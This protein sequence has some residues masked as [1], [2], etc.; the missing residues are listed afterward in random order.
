MKK[1]IMILALLLFASGMLFSQSITLLGSTTASALGSGTGGLPSLTWNVPAGKNRA[2]IVTVFFE[3][4]GLNNYPDDALPL[5]INGIDMQGGYSVPFSFWN[6]NG[7]G[8]VA[9]SDIKTKVYK[10]TLTDAQS[11]PTGTATF[12][13]SGIALPTNAND[14][15]TVSVAVF[16]NVSPSTSFANLYGG[17]T[18]NNTT[19]TFSGSVPVGT[20]VLGRTLADNLNFAIGRTSKDATLGVNAGWTTITNTKVT[21]GPGT[22]NTGWVTPRPVNEHDGVSFMAV[23]QDGGSARTV[24]FSGVGTPRVHMVGWQASRLNPLAK[25]SITGNVYHDIDGNTNI[26]GSA[27]A[28][29]GLYVNVVGTDGNVVASAAVAVDGTFTVPSSLTGVTEGDTYTL[30]LSKNQGTVGQPAPAIALNNDWTTVGEATSATGNDGTNNGIITLTAGTTNISG[31]RYGI[32]KVTNAVTPG[33]VAADQTVISGGNPAAFTVTTAATGSG[34]MSYQWQSSTDSGANWA[35]ISGATADT[36]DVPAGIAITTQYRRAAVSTLSGTGLTAYSNVIT[37]T[38]QQSINA[39]NICPATT[40][41]LG[42]YFIGTAPAGTSLVWFNNNTHTGS[43][44]SNPSAVGAGTYYAYYYDAP[45]TCYS[46]PSIPVNVTINACPALCTT[47]D[48]VLWYKADS[49]VN[50]ATGV[51]ADNT[52]LSTWFDKT[53]GA[54][55]NGGTASVH[56]GS[57]AE[58]DLPSMPYYRYDNSFNFNFNPVVNFNSTNNGQAVQFSTP[59]KG[60]QTVFTVFKSAGVNESTFYYSGLLYGGDAVKVNP[61]DGDGVP[62]SDITLGVR[63]PGRL[64][65][66]GGSNGDFNMLGDI[67]LNTIPSIGTF[68]RDRRNDEEVYMSMYGSGST[69]ILNQNADPTNTKTG[70]GRDLINSLRIGKAFSAYEEG[71]AS[72]RGKLNGDFAELLVYNYVLTDADRAK[73]ESYLAI[74]YGITLT[75]GTKQ[76][77][78]LVGNSNYNYVTNTGTVIRA[79][80]PVYKYDVFGLGKDNYYS[81]NQ[82]I[83]KSVNPGEIL[84]ASTNSNFISGNL[85]TTRTAITGDMKYL[86]FGNN[87]G[88]AVAVTQQ[89]TELP[90]GITTRLNREWKAAHFNTD[91][92]NIPNFSLRFDIS[93]TAFTAANSSNLR[94]LIDTDGDG[95]FTTGTVTQFSPSNF[96]AGSEAIFTSLNITNGQVFTL[97]LIPATYCYKPGATTGGTVRDTKV[98]ISAL[99]RAGETDTDN[100]PMTR[101]GGWLALEAKTKAFVPNRVA[102]TDADNNSSTPDTP[103]GI[104]AANFVEGM[105]VYDTTNKC[106]KMYT[107]KT[108]DT[109]MAWHCVTTQACPD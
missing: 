40:V 2:M 74:K 19:N 55:F 31:L 7:G 58:T 42:S 76:A 15:V 9:S 95:D 102:F 64:V 97:G 22:D 75:G 34:T 82:R 57:P 38:V 48:A 84:T 89:T 103:V 36:Y 66:G 26:N 3:R 27:T 33:V 6:Q 81:L 43:P 104:A 23:T 29:G 21:N 25:P 65:L 51:P 30:Q 14:E 49:G 50:T 80:E 52:Q 17:S 53:T 1:T 68:K 90:T 101:K 11:L 32:L 99:G 96:T 35:D 37:V 24:T 44:V 61:T 47:G 87:T 71:L 92:A 12:D 46:P 85:D 39:S 63:T 91:A 59:A 83:S 56:P 98:G 69:D 86:L 8:D 5:K 77:G 54:A 20:A 88:S 106:L 18:L 62:K 67:Q 4:I 73:V 72:P 16:G 28:G 70:E 108:G 60:C 10:F 105:M 109:V 45:N 107:L 94:L 78:H 100:W 79:S 41:N 13:F 93:G